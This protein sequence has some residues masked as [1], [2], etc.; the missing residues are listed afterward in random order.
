MEPCE[1]NH[2]IE[3][4]HDG[5]LAG[6]ANATREVETHLATCQ[7][8]AAQLAE[9]RAMSAL[10]ASAAV[11]PQMKLSQIARHRLHRH[12]SDV[13]DGGLLRLGWAM[14]AVAASVLL[15]A[16][17]WLTRL[18]PQK[19]A[20]VQAQA[21]GA[22]TEAAPPPWMGVTVVAEND[23]DVREASTTPAAE[24]YLADASPRN[25]DMP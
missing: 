16:S 14:S 2:R 9:L 10:F 8:C 7:A 6:D 15:V 13:M 24:W 3:A 11:A 18:T 5:E 12:V 17:V 4:Y 20:A 19:P 23:P 21:T 25:N 1:F 22:E